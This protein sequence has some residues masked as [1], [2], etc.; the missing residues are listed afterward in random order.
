M[1]DGVPINQ[2]NL[3]AEF[4]SSIFD[5]RRASKVA[6]A[7]VKYGSELAAF[8]DTALSDDVELAMQQDV[9]RLVMLYGIIL[10]FFLK[11]LLKE[12]PYEGVP[13]EKETQGDWFEIAFDEQAVSMHRLLI[14]R[15]LENRS[16]S[17]GELT[18]IVYPSGRTSDFNKK[19]A[20]VR[21]EY[22]VPMEEMWLW[23]IDEITA[24]NKNGKEEVRRYDISAGPALRLFSRDVFVPLRRTL[25]EQ[26]LERMEVKNDESN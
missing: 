5:Q 1:L 10:E 7:A 4:E 15:T 17:F 19:R 12:F 20:R 23:K 2:T 22:R 6:K 13:L 3:I 8:D 16:V 18:D 11:E 14:R 25:L 21:D 24:V 9:S 26:M